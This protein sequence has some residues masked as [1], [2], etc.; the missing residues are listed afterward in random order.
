[1][2]EE[3]AFE[4][5]GGLFRAEQ[6]ERGAEGVGGK[7]GADFGEAPVSLAAAGRSE[8]EADLG[9]KGLEV[10]GVAWGGLD[11]ADFGVAGVDLCFEPESGIVAA[12]AEDDGVG[13]DF[14]DEVE[15][16]ITVGVGGEVELL[17]VAAAG[18]FASGGAEEEALAGLGGFEPAAGG[19]GV[20]VADEEDGLAFVFDHAEGE[21]MGGGV[22]AHH[23]GGEDEDAAAGETEL[24]GLAFLEDDEVKG[25]VELQLAMLAVGAV[26][27]EV[28]DLGENAPEAADVDGLRFEAAGVGEEGEEGEDFLGA[29]EGEGG[30]QDRGFTFEGGEEGLGEA[31]DFLF[32]AEVGGKLAVAAGGLEDEDVGLDVL[33]PGAF[34]DRL[35]AEGDIAGV[36]ERLTVAPDHDAGGAEAVAGVEEFEGGRGVAGA[37]FGAGGPFDLAVI[38]EALENGGDVVDFGVGEEGVFADAE[39]LALAEHDV[40][41]VM[42][43]AFD[44]EVAEF[45]HEDMG[46]GEVAD[47][48]GE[49]AHVVVVA[50]GE[51]DGV[52]GGV[53]DEV[54]E[55]EAGVAFA[56]GVG[57][58]VEQ[59]TVS[60][61]FDQVGAGPDF[62]V[63]V[64]VQD[65]HE[66]E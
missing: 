8:Q 53:L 42:E 13:G 56:F 41:G 52:E 31:F 44:E 54:V 10:E 29:A 57:A 61:E 64:E 6:E 22:F 11:D 20:G 36:E 25:F 32:A 18:E 17:E 33:E 48:D 12:V 30:D 65:P 14:A 7:L 49:G 50:M 9:H 46:L 39:F 27:F 5:V 63:G 47:G 34:E 40:D 23:A 15:E 43:D 37:G 45:G 4:L 51:G 16:F 2:V 35:V 60:V 55:R 21:V 66:H 28:V 38:A 1:M 58:G 3:L 59:Q 26:G 24:F 19:I 62:R